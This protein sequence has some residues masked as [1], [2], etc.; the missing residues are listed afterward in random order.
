M[1][2][3]DRGKAESFIPSLLCG[4][5]HATADHPERLEHAENLLLVISFEKVPVARLA[6]VRAKLQ[7]GIPRRIEDLPAATR[8]QNTPPHEVGRTRSVCR[9]SG[10]G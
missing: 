2:A 5:N 8:Q 7:K 4:E 6:A 1:N 3:A 10:I 9:S